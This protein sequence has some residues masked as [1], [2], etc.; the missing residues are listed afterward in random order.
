[1]SSGARLAP[2]DRVLPDREKGV[3]RVELASTKQYNRNIPLYTGKS[4]PTRARDQPM[5]G[6][7]LATLHTMK[8]TLP[9]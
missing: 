7:D 6:I 8:T 9:V 5:A 3:L 4:D 1:M 2:S